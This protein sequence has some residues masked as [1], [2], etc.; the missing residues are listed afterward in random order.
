[1][2]HSNGI[3]S[4]RLYDPNP[5]VLKNSGIS[6]ALGVRNEDVQ[7]IASSPAAADSWISV[8]YITVG[9]EVIPG[10]L[11]QFVLPAMK[12]LHISLLA[13]GLGTVGVTT[14]VSMSVLGNSYPPSQGTFS[15]NAA[16]AMASIVSFLKGTGQPLLAN[17]YPYF[18]YAA[19]PVDISL[20]YALFT[21]P[22]PVVRD[23]QF[24]YQNL[25]DAMVDAL[26]AAM[27]KVAGAG[28]PVVRT[29]N[30]NFIAHVLSG[31]GTPRNPGKPLE[32]FVFAMFN[33]DLK[34]G[35]ITERNFGLFYP[36]KKPVYPVNFH[37]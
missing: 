2:Y 15:P 11:T 14:V 25:F 26:H 31:R 20:S 1:M 16:S 28:V 27:E 29:Y 36:N 23:G 24:L 8:N 3:T 10:P 17:V 12:N 21:S 30:N 13:A 34:P 4:L 5:G 32:A 7:A 9:N 18:A 22:M 33:E 19:D 37:K 6:V 35:A